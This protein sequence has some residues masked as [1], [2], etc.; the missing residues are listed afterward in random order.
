V[1]STKETLKIPVFC[2]KIKDFDLV[3]AT[4]LHCTKRSAVQVS[5]PSWL[6]LFGFKTLRIRSVDFEPVC[7]WSRGCCD[8]QDIGTRTGCTEVV[9]GSCN[10][11]AGRTARA[12]VGLIFVLETFDNLPA[13]IENS[14]LRTRIVMVLD[15]DGNALAVLRGELPIVGFR[16]AVEHARSDDA[17]FQHPAAGGFQAIAAIRRSSG[18]CTHLCGVILFL[19]GG[20]AAVEFAAGGQ[21]HPGASYEDQD[22][23]EDRQRRNTK[24]QASVFVF[25]QPYANAGDDADQREGDDATDKEVIRVPIG[26]W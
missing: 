2:L 11:T 10:H 7:A 4:H 3:G 18:A 12:Q 25:Q 20:G 8:A 13:G 19:H 6:K 21:V 5:C 22:E 17:H 15:G 23:R 1:R 14:D 9:V 16:S 26:R 24:S